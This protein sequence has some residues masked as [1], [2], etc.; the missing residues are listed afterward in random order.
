MSYAIEFYSE[1][2]R[3]EIDGLP[4]GFRVRFAIFADRMIEHG[5]NLG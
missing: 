3:K 1:A 2:V 4:V 5:A